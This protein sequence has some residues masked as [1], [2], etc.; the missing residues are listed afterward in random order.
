MSKSKKKAGKFPENERSSRLGFASSERPQKVHDDS[1]DATKGPDK[2]VEKIEL[3]AFNVFIS[4]V[5]AKIMFTL[6]ASV[7]V[8]ISTGQDASLHAP[9][10][11]LDLKAR[12][13][14]FGVQG[15]DPG[16]RSGAAK[17]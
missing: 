14:F 12:R 4:F 2:L 17:G 11:A 16:Q 15:D 13:S 8:I 7:P 9:L 6:S 3:V 5:A 10:P 1:D